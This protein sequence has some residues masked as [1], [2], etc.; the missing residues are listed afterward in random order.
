M[1]ASSSAEQS[2]TETETSSDSGS[3]SSEASSESSSA[4]RDGDAAAPAESVD[5]ALRSGEEDGGHEHDD[6]KPGSAAER[7]RDKD[8]KP[9][10]RPLQ[11]HD[12]GADDARYARALQKERKA[13]HEERRKAK[14]AQAKAAGDRNP[15]PAGDAQRGQHEFL[16]RLKDAGFEETSQIH[17]WTV[18]AKSQLQEAERLR[19]KPQYKMKDSGFFHVAYDYTGRLLKRRQAQLV[20]RDKDGQDKYLRGWCVVGATPAVLPTDLQLVRFVYKEELARR[21]GTGKNLLI[22]AAHPDNC[23]R[24]GADEFRGGDYDGDLNWVCWNTDLLT[25][26]GKNGRSQIRCWNLGDDYW[27]GRVKQIED[28]LTD[29]TRKGDAADAGEEEKKP[30]A[31]A[32]QV[33]STASSSSSGATSSKNRAPL[34]GSNSTLDEDFGIEENLART[35]GELDDDNLLEDVMLAVFRRYTQHGGGLQTSSGITGKVTARWFNVVEKFGPAHPRS[36]GL[37]CLTRVV[38]DM[39][40]GNLSPRRLGELLRAEQSLGAV[41]LASW[42]TGDR[43]RA[44]KILDAAAM[45][46][47]GTLSMRTKDVEKSARAHKLT[48]R[49]IREVVSDLLAE[50][51][52][53]VDVAAP[54]QVGFSSAGDKDEPSRVDTEAEDDPDCDLEDQEVFDNMAVFGRDEGSDADGPLENDFYQD[55]SADGEDP[56]LDAPDVEHSR[57]SSSSTASGPEKARTVAIM[58]NLRAYKRYRQLGHGSGGAFF[59]NLQKTLR[60]SLG[61][62]ELADFW[63][64]EEATSGSSS[65]AAEGEKTRE[66]NC[67]IAMEVYRIC[68]REIKHERKM[69]LRSERQRKK[70]LAPNKTKSLCTML[71]PLLKIPFEVFPT[72]LLAI[73]TNAVHKRKRT[74]ARSVGLNSKRTMLA[75]KRLRYSQAAISPEFTDGTPIRTTRDALAAGLLTPADF[76]PL[77]VYLWGGEYWSADNR[78]LW[79]FKEAARLRNDRESSAPCMLAYVDALQGRN[80]TKLRETAEPGALS[81]EKLEKKAHDMTMDMITTDPKVALHIKRIQELWHEKMGDG[82]DVRVRNYD[83]ASVDD[84]SAAEVID[85]VDEESDSV[86]CVMLD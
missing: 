42:R 59:D 41:P 61:V 13:V 38:L 32:Q 78:R 43:A 29:S 85:L 22:L 5:A 86:D 76:P 15:F 21:F 36:I 37:A 77:V 53:L 63:P 31:L 27:A 34:L 25:L 1:L 23:E 55:L 73:K 67:A 24:G 28:F 54:E 20:F 68:M 79:C 82:L 4:D 74:P 7:N 57:G 2:D 47:H 72:E 40:K 35:V 8:V 49:D 62:R 26:L 69:E 33:G 56:A 18:E 50:D 44:Q 66:R 75:V 65:G 39:I 83:G 70:G 10:A 9:G 45:K 58:N 11:F 84:G 64:L 3:A 60:Q 6:P 19:K 51:P 46:G 16:S 30:G 71:M 80:R 12:A 48:N 17:L 14:A 81:L 52:D